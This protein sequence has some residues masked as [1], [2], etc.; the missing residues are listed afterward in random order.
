M[1]PVKRTGRLL[2]VF[3]VTLSSGCFSFSL[4]SKDL[5]SGPSKGDPRLTLR[6]TTVDGEKIMLKKPWVDR[7]VLG[8]GSEGHRGTPA[9]QNSPLESRPGGRAGIR[10]QADASE[11]A[12]HLRGSRG[13]RVVW[14]RAVLNLFP[15]GPLRRPVRSGVF[16]GLIP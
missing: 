6:V 13:R 7:W 16:G 5:P 3:C 11:P 14:F 12:G 4:L 9:D 15:F 2:L 8:G 1:A 10:R